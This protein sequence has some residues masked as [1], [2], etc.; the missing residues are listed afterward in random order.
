MPILNLQLPNKHQ[1][2]NGK[3]TPIQQSTKARSPITLPLHPNPQPIVPESKHNSHGN[4]NA[5]TRPN[6]E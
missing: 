3:P 5:Q 4:Q 1:A 2:N 6:H